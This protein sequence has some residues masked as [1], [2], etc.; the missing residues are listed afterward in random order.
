MDRS[1]HVHLVDAPVEP[2]AERGV[3]SNRA[4]RLLLLVSPAGPGWVGR[5]GSALTS[6]PASR[7]HGPA[8]A[9]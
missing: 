9:R 2:R 7:H 5:R 1:Y 6:I 3:R 4:A 8:R